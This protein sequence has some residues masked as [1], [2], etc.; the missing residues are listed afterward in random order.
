[1]AP[2]T[3]RQTDTVDEIVVRGEGIVA[4]FSGQDLQPRGAH[5]ALWFA[6]P[7]AMRM[8]RDLYIDGAVCPVA[9]D[10]ARRLATIWSNLA[11]QVFEPIEI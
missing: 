9:L 10:N 3:F 7:L 6:L 11:K 4:R 8:E 1:M 2:I 5:V